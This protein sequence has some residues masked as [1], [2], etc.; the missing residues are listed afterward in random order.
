MGPS[1]YAKSQGQ[2]VKIWGLLGDGLMDYIVL[3]EVVNA[4]GKK[5]TAN[6]KGNRYELMFKRHFKTW[7]K[8][9]FPRFD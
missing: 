7:K 4:K 1:S 3:P 5:T 9:M 8:K 2:P 6:M